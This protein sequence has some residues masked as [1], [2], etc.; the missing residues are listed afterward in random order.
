M[1]NA[2]VRTLAPFAAALDGNTESSN[3]YIKYYVPLC[4]QTPLLMQ[5]AMYTAACFLN[6]TGHMDKTVT[7]AHKSQA[8]SMLNEN[9]WTDSCSND[10]TV[11]AH[12]QLILNEWYWGA[13][14]DLRAHLRG[15]K[16]MVCLR[17]GF[18]SLGL[19]G[20]IAKMAIT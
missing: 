10:E 13:G 16:E 2:V 20:L 3:T 12:T 7:M 6:E 9:L 8:I 14:T 1:S 17:G 19:H 18:R 4:V 15:L 5:T 11:A